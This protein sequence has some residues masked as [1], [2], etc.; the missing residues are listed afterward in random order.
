MTNFDCDVNDKFFV[1]ETFQAL[2]NDI[3]LIYNDITICFGKLMCFIILNK[4]TICTMCNV[5]VIVILLYL[6]GVNS[7]SFL[8]NKLPTSSCGPLFMANS[9]L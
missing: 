8:Q 4:M 6:K 1:L 3:W 9:I 2:Q 5:V 7:Y